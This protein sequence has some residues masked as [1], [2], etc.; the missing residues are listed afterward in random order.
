MAVTVQWYIRLYLER[1]WYLKS[2]V[3]INGGKNG[4]QEYV[5]TGLKCFWSVEVLALGANVF[6]LVLRVSCFCFF[7]FVCFR[8]G[9][10]F[11]LST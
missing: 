7:L 2:I 10:D 8:M 9:K 3:V 6:N 11:K 4:I 5:I 1:G